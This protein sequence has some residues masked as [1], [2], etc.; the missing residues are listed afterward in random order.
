[1]FRPTLS[2]SVLIRV[3]CE[4]ANI[5][6]TI[7]HV[8]HETAVQH[9]AAHTRSIM[10]HNTQCCATWL[11]VYV[12]LYITSLL[13]L[14]SHRLIMRQLFIKF[15]SSVYS[16]LHVSASFMRPSSGG[17]FLSWS[18]LHLSAKPHVSCFVVH[19]KTVSKSIKFVKFH[20][21]Q[22]LYNI[23]LTYILTHHR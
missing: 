6:R 13:Y 23:I 10:L 8:Q 1:M 22:L 19:N 21:I 9:Y 4:M 16:P 3:A 18:L 17:Y 7:S 11:I 5:L 20:K 15:S 2:S 12:P 14:M